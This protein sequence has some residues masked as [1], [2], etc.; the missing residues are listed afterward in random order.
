MQ[1]F[2]ATLNQ[3][4]VLLITI[5]IGY[6]LYK[7]DLVPKTTDTVLSKLLSMVMLPALCFK[8]L[9]SNLTSDVITYKWNLL[10]YGT[11]T[12]LASYGIALVISRFFAKEKYTQNI[13]TY[14]FTI[15]NLGYFGYSLVGGVFGEK[16]LMDMM[17]FVVPFNIFIYSI[18]YAMLTK[19]DKI[20][21]KTLINP[22]CISLLAGAA[23]GLS[24]IEI[25]EFVP[26]IASSL[27]NCMGPT[28]MLLTGFVIA[29][30]D[31][32]KLMLNIRVIIA[33]VLRLIVIPAVIVLLLKLIGASQNVIIIALGTTAMP[34]GLNA[35]VFPA[36]CGKDTK[37]GASMALIS[38]I[39]CI[40]TIPVMF[41]LFL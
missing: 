19:G 35:V 1:Y 5:V 33:S 32:K 8:T 27:G 6:F 13:Y 34:L 37:T 4:L 15:A 7:K 23:I 39:L 16:V 22:V 29:Q 28:A 2:S 36:A 38:N 25:P 40:I 26:Q 41:M 11:A 9:M 18:G 24:G 14:S 20:T 12:M 31:L 17:I 3:I 10:V 30:Y 21:L